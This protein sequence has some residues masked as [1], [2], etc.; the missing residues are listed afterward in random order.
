MGERMDATRSRSLWM[1]TLGAVCGAALLAWLGLQ[2]APERRVAAAPERSVAAPARASDRPEL[3]SPRPESLPERIE[4]DVELAPRAAALFGPEPREGRVLVRGVVR[5]PV[6]DLERTSIHVERTEGALRLANPARDWARSDAAGRFEVDVT[7]LVRPRDDLHVAGGVVLRAGSPSPDD[8]QRSQLLVQADHPSCEPA[9]VRIEVPQPLPES[10][11]NEGEDV[12]L[13][14]ELVLASASCIRG[15][16]T[17]PEGC[18]VT[19]VQVVAFAKSSSGGW[20]VY[21]H[22]REDPRRDRKLAITASLA[23]AHTPAEDGSYSIRVTPGA[24]Y[25][26]VAAWPGLRPDHGQVEVAV[27]GEFR[28][29]LALDEG[30]ALRG[31]LRLDGAPAGAGTAVSAAHQCGDH[32]HLSLGAGRGSLCWVDGELGW[33]AAVTKTDAKGR[34]ELKG[35]CAGSYALR[36]V[37]LGQPGHYARSVPLGE[38]RAPSDDAQLGPLLARAVLT[39]DVEEDERIPF[40]LRALGGRASDVE[41]GPFEP[42]RDGVATLSLAPSSVYEVVQGGAA[43][44]RIT[45]GQA[46]SKTTWRIA[47]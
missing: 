3:V 32:G 7:D 43:V 16:V 24:I 33:A 15:I 1:S 13:E 17:V 30:V 9:S 8:E 14:V 44:G 11:A 19:P 18:D 36:A 26:V 37:G 10:E 23:D 22:P 35:L 21:V 4:A 27:S 12:V 46:G 41:L 5:A 34:F 38:V 6:M 39:F 29:D 28:L 45:T 47:P 25:A 20:D 2:L 31:T 40:S 42:D